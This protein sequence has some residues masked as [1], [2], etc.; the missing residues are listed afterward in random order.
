MLDY[1]H[2]ENVAVIK[3][4]DINFKD[5]FN[6]LTGDTGAG[7]SI[8]IDCINMLLGAKASKD[9]IRHGE[10]RAVVSA[11]FSCVNNSVYAACD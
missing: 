6:V 7:K 1:L 4:L 11:Y 8:I 5:G 2:I 3:K 10:E 9:F